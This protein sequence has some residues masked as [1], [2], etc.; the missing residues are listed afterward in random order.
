MSTDTSPQNQAFALAMFANAG[1]NQQQDQN[2]DLGSVA[3]GMITTAIT[4]ASSTIGR[5]KIV[6]GP[7]VPAQILGPAYSLNAMYVAQSVEEPSKYVIAI[8]GTNFNAVFDKVVEDLFVFA[9]VPWPYGFLESVLVAPGAN[10]ALG[11]ALGLTILQNMTPSGS[12]PGAGTK[13]VDFLK[14]LVSRKVE[15]TVAGHSLGGALA[16]TVALWLANTQQDILSLNWDPLKN[17]TI[18]VQAFAGPT[19]GNSAFAKFLGFKLGDGLKS[20]YNSL[21]VIPHAWQTLGTPSLAELYSLYAGCV[22]KDK[23][24]TIESGWVALAALTA[25]ALSAGG[26]YTAL[27]GLQSFKGTFF[28]LPPIYDSSADPLQNYFNQLGFQH[29]PGYFGRFSFDLS[30]APW[31]LPAQAQPQASSALSQ[32]INDALTQKSPSPAD[33]IRALQKRSPGKI[34]VGDRSVAAPTGS[35]D[36]QAAYVVSLVHAELL[37]NGGQ[38]PAS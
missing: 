2:T 20:Y 23:Q 6:W 28:S 10:I 37:K 19:P 15:I 24:G 9:Q 27:P 12:L 29:I 13:L 32:A 21:D 34:L 26:S 38:S 18:Q 1:Q 8:G 11:T 30:W 7:A 25:Q 35:N 31:L 22:D 14:T 36:P 16:P 3:S 5:W 33:V 4:K 17:A